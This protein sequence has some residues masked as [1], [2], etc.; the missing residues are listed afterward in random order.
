METSAFYRGRVSKWMSSKKDLLLRQGLYPGFK[1]RAVPMPAN[2]CPFAWLHLQA[3]WSLLLRSG[4]ARQLLARFGMA[5][6]TAAPRPTY[7]QAR[8]KHIRAAPSCRLFAVPEVAHR[9]QPRLS[10]QGVT[11]VRWRRS[12]GMGMAL[13][14]VHVSPPHSQ[15]V[16]YRSK[17]PFLWILLRYSCQIRSFFQK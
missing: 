15:A 13:P 1:A 4:C 14:A 10:Q 17:D 7:S 5:G 8:L 6:R 12:T 11:K 16:L 9:L 3:L 2:S